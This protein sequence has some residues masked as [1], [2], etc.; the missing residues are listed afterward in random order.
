MDMAGTPLRPNLA[1]CWNAFVEKSLGD[2][3]SVF[4]VPTSAAAAVASAPDPTPLST[5]SAGQLPHMTSSPAMERK[6]SV[7]VDQIITD[8]LCTSSPIPTTS[9]GNHIPMVE[10]PVVERKPRERR[11]S[12]SATATAHYGQSY[13]ASVQLPLHSVVQMM[14]VQKEEGEDD[15]K[16]DPISASIKEASAIASE[17]EE[18]HQIRSRRGSVIVK[19]M[20]RLSK[21]LSTTDD[22]FHLSI[23]KIMKERGSLWI[24]QLFWCHNR[25]II[26]Q[27]RQIPSLL[28]EVFVGT[29]AGLLM[30]ISVQGA[31]GELYS[32]NKEETGRE[33]EVETLKLLPLKRRVSGSIL[34]CDKCPLYPSIAPVL[35]F[36]WI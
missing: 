20:R 18:E 31:D 33:R 12:F 30:G 9:S 2:P 15:V 13:T 1:E 10:S 19:T 25:Y 28:L 5:T 36:D 32:G 6:Q 8:P 4:S 11:L 16:I 22:V 17:A 35:S 14:E 7:F 29:L 24:Q 21:R 27:L 23:S 34:A 3:K 26:Q